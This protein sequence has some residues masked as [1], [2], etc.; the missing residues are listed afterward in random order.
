MFLVN[1]RQTH[2]SAA[3]SRRSETRH[4]LS[5]SYGVNLP[6]SLTSANSIAFGYSPRLP[7][8]VYGTDTRESRVEVFLGSM[9]RM[10]WLARKLASHLC[11]TVGCADLP[12]Q[13]GYALRPGNQSR[14]IF[15][16]C[17]TPWLI[18]TTRWCRNIDLLPIDYAFRPR[19]RDR[20]T[21][22]GM[23]F[24]RKP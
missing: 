13:P 18:T 1:S 21:L 24:P 11:F 8:L 5:R 3:Q 20:L 7:V 6:S 9:I 4:P 15:H 2:F 10:S 16:F 19:L 22:G 14:L 17:V 12:T 23:T